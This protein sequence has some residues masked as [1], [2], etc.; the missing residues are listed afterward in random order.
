MRSIHD[1]V[2]VDLVVAER[3]D[4]ADGVIVLDLRA[5]DG[6][7]LPAWDPGAHID[8]QLTPELSRQYSLC[9]DPDRHDVWRIGVLLEPESRGGSRFVHDKLHVGAEV[10]ARGPRNHFALE[11]S[12]R[13]VFVAGGIG[14]TPIVP[15]IGEA[16]RAGAEWTLLYGGRTLSSMAFRE[17][18][19]LLGGGRVTVTPQD[20]HGL[21]D[22]PALLADARADTLVYVC[23][24]EPLLDAVTALTDPWPAGT[25]HLERFTP[26][27]LGPIGDASFEVELAQS[28]LT[29]TVPPDRSILD[30]VTEAGVDAPSSCGEGTCGTCETVVLEGTPEHRDSLLTPEEQA[31][32]ETMMICVSRAACPRLV[33]DI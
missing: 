29:L 8:L 19:A 6:S 14:V 10:R 3:V 32:N 31:A 1:E 18:L 12:P 16:E 28:G 26:K 2:D 25:L 30:V 17:E 5:A 7:D 9:G 21:L 27:T 4:A 20:T 15:M 23:G 33:L 24:P 22:L 11:P 13:Y